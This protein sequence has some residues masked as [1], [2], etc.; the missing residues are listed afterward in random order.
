[1]HP[2]EQISTTSSAIEKKQAG[3]AMGLEAPSRTQSRF[4]LLHLST[5]SSCAFKIS[6]LNAKTI[7]TKMQIHAG[8]KNAGLLLLPFLQLEIS[9]QAEASASRSARDILLPA[10]L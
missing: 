4:L 2:G 3:E 8:K 10:K 6:L 9:D 1:M 7:A 5:S